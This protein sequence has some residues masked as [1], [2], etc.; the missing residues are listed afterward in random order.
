MQDGAQCS[1]H[2]AHDCCSQVAG[3]GRTVADV[4]SGSDS[5]QEATVTIVGADACNASYNGTLAP[6]ILCAGTSS[7]QYNRVEGIACTCMLA[8]K[9]I[10]VH[11]PHA[12]NHAAL[13]PTTRQAGPG[14]VGIPA[15]ATQGAHCTALS[16]AHSCR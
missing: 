1:R 7:L 2:V 9:P 13:S 8:S 16:E 14:V 11:T 10:A 3:W 6:T 4:P 12:P 15:R 5:L